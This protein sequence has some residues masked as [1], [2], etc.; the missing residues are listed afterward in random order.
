[1]SSAP[2]TST[3]SPSSAVRRLPALEPDQLE[4]VRLVGEFGAGLVLGDDP[5]HETLALADDALHLLLDGLEVLGGERLLDVEVVVEAVGDGRADAELRL[6]I[7][8]CTAWAST[9]AAE[10]RRM[11]RPSGESIVTGSTASVVVVVAARSF[12]SPLTRMATTE[13]SVNRSNPVWLTRLL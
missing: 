13:R 3:D 5:A 2:P 10:W 9:C 8:R 6:G 4:L 12:S 7:D 11:L 1:M